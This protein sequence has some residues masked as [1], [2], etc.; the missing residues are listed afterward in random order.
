MADV[1]VDPRVVQR[2]AQRARLGQQRVDAVDT[3]FTHLVGE[4][5]QQVRVLRLAGLAQV[6]LQFFDPVPDVH[7]ISAP[8]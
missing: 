1:D 5:V 3:Q 6:A 8:V 7:G 2:L 4:A